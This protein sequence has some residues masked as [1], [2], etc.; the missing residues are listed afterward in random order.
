MRTQRAPLYIL[1]SLLVIILSALAYRQYYISNRDAEVERYL[2]QTQGY[3]QS[4]IQRIDT[5]IG[6]APVV[7]TK[8]I[9]TDEPEARYFYKK[10]NGSIRQYS[11]A[12]VHGVNPSFNYKHLDNSQ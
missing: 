2:L 10:E 11:S 8:V 7:S 1:L 5:S 6:K 12:P 9:F 4:D 3:Q